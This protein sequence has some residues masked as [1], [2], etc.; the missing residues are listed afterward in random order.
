MA[1]HRTNLTGILKRQFIDLTN[2][3]GILEGSHRTNLTDTIKGS[4]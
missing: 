3:M 2:L 1:V 4:S